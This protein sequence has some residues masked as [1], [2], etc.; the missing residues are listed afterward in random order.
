MMQALARKILAHCLAAG[1]GA[2][3]A[4][5]AAAQSQVYPGKPLRF[6]VGYPA[7]G[8]ADFASRLVMTKL[9]ERLGQPVIV[10]NRSGNEGAVGVDVVAK[11]SPDGYTI[12]AGS[13][14]SLVVNVTLNPNLPY[15]P[16]RDLAPIGMVAKFP[17][18]LVANVSF[19]AQDVRELVAL[20]KPPRQLNY[21]AS[22]VGGAMHL[23]GVLLA[24]MARID[25]VHIPYKG[26][27]P[28]MIDLIGGQ[29]PLAIVDV[30]STRSFIKS[31]KI[32]A[33]ATLGPTRSRLAPD[34][35]TMVESGFPGLV[36]QSWSG[37][38][39]PARTPPEIVARLGSHLVAILDD[40]DTRERFLTVG[41]EASPSSPE[42]FTA[43]IKSEISRWAAVIKEGKIKLD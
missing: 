29:I 38:V 9:S 23:G 6:M 15:S 33:L 5:Q 3:A 18:I 22:G 17:L 25:L 32:K 37:I 8:P 41:M 40:A 2:F 4:S 14:G 7:G 36:A 28:T 42:E 21:G 19:P 43:F 26:A 39:A 35:P 16:T 31:G 27:Q 11:S 1:I 24:Q 13:T 30:A 34:I 12:G 20:A 10:D